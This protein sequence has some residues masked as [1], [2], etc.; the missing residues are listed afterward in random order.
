APGL[1]ATAPPTPP[2]ASAPAGRGSRQR[3]RSNPAWC[4]SRGSCQPVPDAVVV[5]EEREAAAALPDHLIIVGLFRWLLA[6]HRLRDARQMQ[7]VEIEL[8]GTHGTVALRAGAHPL[9]AFHPARQ[10]CRIL[11]D[12]VGGERIGLACGLPDLAA[13]RLVEEVAHGAERH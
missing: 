1:P 12:L 13:H 7:W 2:G 10:E 3:T 11:P 6:S 4:S 9:G 8:A 5:G